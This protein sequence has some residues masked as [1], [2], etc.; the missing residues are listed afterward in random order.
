MKNFKKIF[1][2]FALLFV[3][4]I[5]VNAQ[6]P[7][8]I[9]DLLTD[10]KLVIKSIEP[11][12]DGDA[13][14]II[15]EYIA[16]ETDN[17]CSASYNE[18]YIKAEVTCGQEEPVTYDIFYEYDPQ[19]I[20]VIEE[21][22]NKITT[23]V[24][25]VRDM[26]LINYWIYGKTGEGDENLPLY[27]GEFKNLADYK[28]LTINVRGGDPGEFYTIIIGEGMYKYRNTVYAVDGRKTITA[29]HAIYVPTDTPN[30]KMMEVAQK[31]IDDI[32]GAGK[33]V[34]SEG[35]S[36]AE[37][38]EYTLDTAGEYYEFINWQIN[39]PEGDMYFL[40]SATNWY[41]V[42]VNGEREY[43]LVII[44]DTEKMLVPTLKTIDLQTDVAII[45]DEANMPYDT[46]I[47]ADKIVSGTEYDKILE[48]LDVAN[49]EMFDL[50]L[51]SKSINENITELEDGSFEVRIPISESFKNMNLVVYYVDE[52]DEKIAYDVTIDGNYAV[53]NTN[54][55]SIYTLVANGTIDNPPTFDGIMNFIILGS[56][57]LIIVIGCGIYLN[58]KRVN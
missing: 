3:G 1:L 37:Y 14:F 23:D 39:D 36:V 10:G 26:E 46:L 8:G 27:S 30:D 11:T 32:F 43:K 7:I 28:N 53:F 55:F 34:L 38:I 12:N 5:S 56:I 19:M 29:N 15:S 50:K 13:G 22:A 35:G 18:D 54:H 47:E 58:K 2:A 49:S 16:Y 44:K 48:I 40:N 51:Y 33:V 20:S 31:R 42:V 24:F 52:N 6:E 41:N 45:S 21:Y 57:S 9:E 25:N 17:N 4:V